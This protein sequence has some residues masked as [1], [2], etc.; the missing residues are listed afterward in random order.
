MQFQRPCA[1][2][3]VWNGSVWF[4]AATLACPLLL[5]LPEAQQK[6]GTHNAE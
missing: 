5:R 1:T 2:Q 6:G 3:C 4:G